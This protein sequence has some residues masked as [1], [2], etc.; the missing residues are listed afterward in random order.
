MVIVIYTESTDDGVTWTTPVNY[1]DSC[2]GSARAGDI[3]GPI[4]GVNV[5]F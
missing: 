3:F 5:N 4:R 2:S 1:L